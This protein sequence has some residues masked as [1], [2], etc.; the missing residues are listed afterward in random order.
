MNNETAN[1]H[2]AAEA[3]KL[4][5]ECIKFKKCFMQFVD[6]QKE[7]ARYGELAKTDLKIK[8]KLEN[9]H[10]ALPGGLSYIQKTF[11]NDIHQL[12]LSLRQLEAQLK[13]A[14]NYELMVRRNEMQRQEALIS[15]QTGSPPETLVSTND[16]QQEI[17]DK[18]LVSHQGK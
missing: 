17:P 10:H 18:N 8:Q 4:E 15:A 16:E 2:L 9:L 7:L 6:M 1:Q 12:G 5:R 3:K 14:F 13:K 11:Q